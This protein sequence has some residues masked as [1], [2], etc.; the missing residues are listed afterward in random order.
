M[1]VCHDADLDPR[2]IEA[3]L[4][5]WHDAGRLRY[6]GI[7]RDMLL[8][9]PE[10]PPD[11]EARVVAMLAEYHA[12]QEGRAA[13]MMAYATTR[14]CR[15]G[16]I[17]AY[18]GGRPID[19]CQACDNCPEPSDAPPGHPRRQVVVPSPVTIEDPTAVILHGVARLPYPMG[20]K[21]LARALQGAPSSSLQVDRF[22]LFGTLA[23]CTQKS[24]REMISQL[25]DKGLLVAYKKGNYRLLRLTTAG[26][27]WL[28]AHPRDP[29][30]TTAPQPRDASETSASQSRRQ[31]EELTA[32]DSVLFERLRAWRLETAK[33]MNKPAF[34]VFSDKVLKRIATSCP[35]TE[36]ELL[37]IRGIGPRKL[38]QYGQTVLDIVARYR[39]KSSQE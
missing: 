4:L 32:Y 23:K 2:A 36:Q 34:V 16:Y 39:E 24:I 10:P 26:Q 13:E 30:G 17:S 29:V 7:G 12:G 19:H 1:T 35:T 28:K 20:S 22:P 38:E 31:A 18:F 27:K 9:L 25:E 14:R 33:G 3:K 11:S 15:H 8:A 37:Q 21:G 5:T 6:R